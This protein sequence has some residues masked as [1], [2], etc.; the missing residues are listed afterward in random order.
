MPAAD[1]SRGC[2]D[3]RRGA[4]QEFPLR[5]GWVEEVMGQV[6]RALRR[7]SGL[8]NLMLRTE[9]EEPPNRAVVLGIACALSPEW[10][11]WD[12]AADYAAGRRAEVLV[13]LHE[14]M[15]RRDDPSAVR[16]AEE[17]V[18]WTA[19]APPPMPIS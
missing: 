10:N 11:T 18:A 17:Y 1:R 9:E 2:E 3:D 8:G 19:A 5:E 7:R 6:E 13:Y 14:A 12:E 15:V 4:E 16:L